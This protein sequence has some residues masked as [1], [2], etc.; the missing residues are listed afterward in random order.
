MILQ[1]VVE[2]LC[3]QVFQVSTVDDAG[4][5]ISGREDKDI[6]LSEATRAQTDGLQPVLDFRRLRVHEGLIGSE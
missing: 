4:L 2:L 1:D 5:G 6:K 3:A